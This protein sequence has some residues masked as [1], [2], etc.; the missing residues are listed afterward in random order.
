MSTVELAPTATVMRLLRDEVRFIPEGA[1]FPNSLAIEPSTHDNNDATQRGIPVR[2]SVWDCARTTVAQASSLRATKQSLRTYFLP[3]AGVVKVRNQF[4]NDRLRVVEDPLVEL[5]GKPGGD[6][7]CGVE[8]LDRG[9]TPRPVWRDM[10][11]ELVRHFSE[12][13]N[14]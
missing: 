9:S 4:A 12:A 1:R 8:G 7:H 6:G 5:S 13:S 10:L 14:A 11:D 3:V 2:V